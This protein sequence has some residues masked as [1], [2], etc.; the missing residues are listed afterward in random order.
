MRGLLAALLLLLLAGCGPI[1]GQMTALTDG[2]KEFRV[3]DGRLA[4]LKG[5]GPLLVYGPFAKTPAAF[6][7]CR[8]ED[9]AN[10][11]DA[12]REA[13]LFRS[14]LY[15]ERN[16][17]RVEATAKHLRTLTAAELKDQL[18]LARPPARIL[19]G[20][21][22]YRHTFIAPARG[23]EMEVGYRLEFYD[24]ASRQT[25]TVEI[26][27]KNLAEETVKQVVAELARR[28]RGS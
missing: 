16:Y 14:E 21:I 3:V 17:D 11:A 19:F 1:F 20:T 8:G 7:I 24:V 5:D 18:G 26:G 28:V 6:Y 15:L 22:L 12:L 4:D 2:V 13:G 10:L 9:A 23:V 27:V 25:T